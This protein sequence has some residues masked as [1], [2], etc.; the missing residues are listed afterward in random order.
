MR[1]SMSPFGAIIT[2]VGGP[3]FRVVY[4]NGDVTSY[5]AIVYDAVVTAGQPAADGDETVETRWFHVSK[6]D[7]IELAPFTRALFDV[8]GPPF[9]APGLE[10]TTLPLRNV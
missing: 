10:G 2:A 8:L 1:A 5:V 6:L 9:A 3:W 4:P 7:G